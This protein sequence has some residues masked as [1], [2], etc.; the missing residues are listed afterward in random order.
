[1][2]E[3]ADRAR[4]SGDESMSDL[5]DF[6]ARYPRLM[7]AL[8]E[9]GDPQGEQSFEAGLALILDGMRLRLSNGHAAN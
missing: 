5:A 4:R 8:M 7:A 3:Q 2:E 6:Q 1:M 9:G